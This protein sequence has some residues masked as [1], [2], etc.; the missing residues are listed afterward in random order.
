MKSKNGSI[1][2][3][4]LIVAGNKT[5]GLHCGGHLPAVAISNGTI[6][7]RVS[8]KILIFS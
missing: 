6:Q 8:W 1:L 4:S 2:I 7:P 5:V 3:L